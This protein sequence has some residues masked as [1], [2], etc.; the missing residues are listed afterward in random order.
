MQLYFIRHAESTNNYNRRV[1][2]SSKGRSDD[3]ELT[4]TGQE[5]AQ[6]LA[7]F[8]R[9]NYSSIPVLERDFQN[10]RGFNFTHLYSSLMIRSVITGTFI[11]QAINLP[12]KAWVDIHEC[13]GPYF[14]DD[15]TDEP[16][17]TEGKNRAYFTA[18]HPELILPDYLGEKGWWNRPVEETEQWFVRAKMVFQELIEKH[19]NSND[20]VAIVSHGGFYNCFLATVLNFPP[21]HC[22]SFILN[23]AA[24][25]RIDFDNGKVRLCYL[26]RVDFLPKHL[27]T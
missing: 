26:N 17:A 16:I 21:G 20:R 12:L 10:A 27:I 23:N 6:L 2:G 4:A 3:P 5:Q 15:Q 22:Y 19:G 25:S 11:S 13:R 24:L 8:L 7:Q 14:R 1:T 18:N 9:N